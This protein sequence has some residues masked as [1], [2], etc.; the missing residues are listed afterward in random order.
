MWKLFGNS[1]WIVIEVIEVRGDCF[2]LI[3]GEVKGLRQ[4]FEKYI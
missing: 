3:E 2:V 4:G 1:L